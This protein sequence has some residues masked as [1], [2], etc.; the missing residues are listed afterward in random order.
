MARTL[1]TLLAAGDAVRGR[2]R[3]R[4]ALLDLVERDRPLVV[5]VHGIAGVG[6]SALLGAFAAD[7]RER[8][9][10]VV[11]IDCRTVEPTER[12]FLAAL[13]EAVGRPLGSVAEAADA[14]GRLAGRVV[15][16]LDT[17]EVFR[18]LDAWLR[19]N[20]VPALHDNTRVVLAG[21]EPPVAAW[22]A[23]F[24]PAL[25][26]LPLANLPP[27]V[28]EAILVEQGLAQPDAVR[29]TAFTH[30]HP[31]SLRLAASAHAVPSTLTGRD[32][33]VTS[34]VA[35]LARIY[36]DDLPSRSRA[37]LDAACVVRRPTLS[38]LAAM[39]P[40]VAPQEAYELLRPLPF[41]AFGPE[42]LVVH[43]TMREAVAAALRATD[44]V[45]HRA[46]IGRAH[47]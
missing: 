24:G 6:K 22:V 36:L 30:G 2:S 29:I 47:V 15:L 46:Q 7:A 10:A 16:T 5:A 14:L 11:A 33:E 3:E 9:A 32:A 23:E 34:V 43:D 38:L 18:L 39:L 31:L 17:Y 13:A 41:V 37:V 19:R 8:G 44:P 26:T 12:G 25:R 21:R 4:A 1:R 40:D 42:G 20:L 27:S 45:T 35:E 28:A